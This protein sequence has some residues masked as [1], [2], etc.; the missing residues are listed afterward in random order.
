MH[1]VAGYTHRTVSRALL[2]VCSK[3]RSDQ[4]Q[5]QQHEKK[6]LLFRGN[7]GGGGGRGNLGVLRSFRDSAFDDAR[8]AFI[9]LKR[10]AR[11][12]LNHTPAQPDSGKR[13]LLLACVLNFATV[14]RVGPEWRHVVVI[15]FHDAGLLPLSVCSCILDFLVVIP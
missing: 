13:V 4:Q 2:S 10:F 3:A 15:W 1:N 12:F 8:S 11:V 9:E 14:F 6:W 7:G 5:Q